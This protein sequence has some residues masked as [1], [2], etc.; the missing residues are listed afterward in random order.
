VGDLRESDDLV[1]Y[2]TSQ[3]GA[4]YYRSYLADVLTNTGEVEEA[5][6]ILG[7]LGLPEDVSPSG[8]MIFFLGARGWTRLARGGY[9]GA[10]SDYARLGEC[11]EAFEMRNPAVLAWRSH[12]ALALVGLER[13]DEARE[14]AREEVE[15]ARGWGAPRALGV[16]L[17]T[18]AQA[19]DGDERLASLRES[20][21]VLEGSSAKLERGRTLVQLGSALGGEEGRRRLREGLALARACGSRPLI[22][23]AGAELARAVAQ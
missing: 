17:R 3:Q 2:A 16:A 18:Q 13:R 22:D 15:L 20:L 8:H 4:I 19:E 21:I 23:E 6:R 1:P 11:M 10:R 7:E 14:L 9:E 5:E 12:L